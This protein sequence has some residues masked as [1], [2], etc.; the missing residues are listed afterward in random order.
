MTLIGR[1]VY[2]T[3]GG[4]LRHGAVVEHQVS[5]ETQVEIVTIVINKRREAIYGLIE[6][7]AE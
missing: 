2:T 1:T 6:G 7:D 4:T 3:N 5:T